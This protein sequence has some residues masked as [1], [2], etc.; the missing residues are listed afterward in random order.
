[1]LNCDQINNS[2]I[3]LRKNVHVLN[4]I[5]MCVCVSISTEYKTNRLKL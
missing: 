5:S 2:G 4:F 1:M 3:N